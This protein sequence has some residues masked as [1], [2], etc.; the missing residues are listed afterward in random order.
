LFDEIGH[1][2][3]PRH[4]PAIDRDDSPG[5]ERGCEQAQTQ[6][7]VRDLLRIA[8][9]TERGAAL[10][11]DCLVLLGDAVGDRRPD[12]ARQMQFTVMPS[13]PSSTASERVSP[14]TPALAA[15]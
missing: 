6:G 11:I 2:C 15:E 3:I 7:H 14:V 5:E 12:R 8:V 10:G 4:Q 9:S 13:R 1:L